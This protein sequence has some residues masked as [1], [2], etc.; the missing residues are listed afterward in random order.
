MHIWIYR[1]DWYIHLRILHEWSNQRLI[2]GHEEWLNGWHCNFLIEIHDW[3]RVD[4]VGPL[5]NTSDKDLA[6]SLF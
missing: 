4:P 3:H 1:T 5:T 6:P 2:M